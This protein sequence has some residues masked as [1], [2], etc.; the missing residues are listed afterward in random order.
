[1]REITASIPSMNGVSNFSNIQPKP[2]SVKTFC[3][4]CGGSGD[5]DNYSGMYPCEKLPDIENLCPECNGE[6]DFFFNKVSETPQKYLSLWD[7]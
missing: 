1:M 3:Y 4:S 5:A 6:G 2:A 7:N